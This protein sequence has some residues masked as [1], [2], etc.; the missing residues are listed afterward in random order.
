[1]VKQEPLIN[2]DTDDR[3][4]QTRVGRIPSESGR[5]GK[6]PASGAGDAFGLAVAHATGNPVLDA[7]ADFRRARRAHAA[8]AS[9]AGSRDDG[10]A[11]VHRH[12]HT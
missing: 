10:I 9:R 7:Q 8:A 6:L 3:S 1:M 4:R 12:S 11:A 5:E 2:D